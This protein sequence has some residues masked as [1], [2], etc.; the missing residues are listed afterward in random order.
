MIGVPEDVE[1]ARALAEESEHDGRYQ[2]EYWD[3]GLVDA[4]PVGNDM[5]GRMQALTVT[6]ISSTTTEASQ[7]ES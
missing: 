4:R 2:F 1:S 3:L 5:K 7:S 6:S